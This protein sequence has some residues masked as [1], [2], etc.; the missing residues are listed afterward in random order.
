MDSVITPCGVFL[1]VLSMSGLDM[2]FSYT[3]FITKMCSLI[4]RPIAFDNNCGNNCYTYL[5]W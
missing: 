1:F 4:Y 3:K 2:P 5:W